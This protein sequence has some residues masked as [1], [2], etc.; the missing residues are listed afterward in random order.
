MRSWLRKNWFETA[1]WG[2]A[3]V[4]ALTVIYLNRQ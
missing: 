3:I 2:A 4:M 1:L